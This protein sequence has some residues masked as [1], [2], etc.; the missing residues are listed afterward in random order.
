MAF[1]GQMHDRSGANSRTPRSIA[2][3]VAD[4]GL[5]EAVVRAFLRPTAA[6]RRLPA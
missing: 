4:V 1:G 2:G 5:D 6:T 3:A